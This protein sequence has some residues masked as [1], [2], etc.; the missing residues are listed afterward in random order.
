MASRPVKYCLP[1]G[2]KFKFEGKRNWRRSSDERW[3]IVTRGAVCGKL[4]GHRNVDGARVAVVRV[5]GRGIFASQHSR[6]VSFDGKGR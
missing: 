5:K 6:K 3:E 2:Y 1:N 4:L